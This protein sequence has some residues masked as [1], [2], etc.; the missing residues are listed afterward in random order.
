MSLSTWVREQV[1]ARAR[2]HRLVWV[3]D[4]Y[5]LLEAG[6][7]PVLQLDL[8]STGHTLL[9]VRNALQL[10]EALEGRDPL[11][12]KLVLLDQSY[13]LRDPHLLPKDAQ[14]G[15]L[16][17]LRAP[18]WKPLVD[19]EALFKPTVRGFLCDLTGDEQ[20][21][22]AVNV[23]PYEKLARDDPHRFARAY[24]TFRRTGHAAC[25]DDLVIVGASA[26]FGTDLFEVSQPLA[27]LELAFHQ[28]QKWEALRDLFNAGRNGCNS[29]PPAGNA[30]AHRRP[31]RCKRGERSA[32]A[33]CP[34][35]PAAALRRTRY[36]IFRFYRHH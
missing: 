21:P 8:V 11:T 19:A 30:T 2:H 31:L 24:D 1:E 36:G 17:P 34:G 22:A 7:I 25:D 16:L 32:G 23:Y 9:A 12:A 20:W 18:D 28:Q 5:E 14:P 13:T 35:D 26:F 10:R 6:E 33:R 15:D 29:Q 4:S 27:A 3:H